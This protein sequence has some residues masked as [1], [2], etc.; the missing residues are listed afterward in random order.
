LIA[1]LQA[2][3]VRRDALFPLDVDRA[4][5]K[6]DISSRRQLPDVVAHAAG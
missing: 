3:G 6:L 5:R 4:F 2:D 1:A